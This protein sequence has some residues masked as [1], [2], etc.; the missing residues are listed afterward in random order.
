M[1][2]GTYAFVQDLRTANNF[3]VPIHPIVPK[4]YILLT[5]VPRDASFFS[6]LHLED[7][8]F[9]IPLQTYS[10]FLFAFEWKG[11]DTKTTTTK[12]KKKSPP[13]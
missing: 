2:G 5:H 13:N 7:E 6:A 11:P 1:P 4:P 12:Q 3:V 9:C 8:F 10:Q